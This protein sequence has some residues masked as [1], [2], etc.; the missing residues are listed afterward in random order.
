MRDIEFG[1]AVFGGIRMLDQSEQ[2]SPA[3]DALSGY[4]TLY[5]IPHSGDAGPDIFAPGVFAESLKSG[6]P[7]RILLDHD[8]A[9]L[10]GSTAD[11][12][13]LT[14]T[15]SG[16][17]FRFT[18]HRGALR[19]IGQRRQMSVAYRVARDGFISRRGE[20]MRLIHQALLSE[21]SIVHK[22]AVPGTCCVRASAAGSL[23]DDVQS[24]QLALR[25]AI[26]REFGTLASRIRELA[27]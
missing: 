10:L 3:A 24:G 13:E 18:P 6:L 21:I 1:A 9:A 17:A 7:I 4:A 16:L 15:A 11:G 26:W 2:E 12:L 23:A 20:R 25:V 8:P 5:D 19:K 22:G 27:V 14:D